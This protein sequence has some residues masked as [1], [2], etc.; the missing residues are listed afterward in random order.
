MSEKALSEIL[1]PDD[2]QFLTSLANEL[3][4]QDT[5]HTATPVIY[6][7]MER[8]K[9]VG[10]DRDYA[11]GV[12]LTL[13]EDGECFY[14]NQVTEAKEWLLEVEWQPEEV[15]KIKAVTCLEDLAIFCEEYD[16]FYSFTGYR[17]TETFTGFF[18]TQSALKRHVAANSYYYKN[19]VS[20]AHYTGW[21]NPELRRLLEIVGKFATVIEKNGRD[22]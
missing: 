17:D 15:A 4:T 5:A 1:T 11:D 16:V 13:G 2:V 6:Q 21:Q 9:D 20:Y 18:L 12:V 14:D 8:T 19:P 7:I 10:I 22:A 3:Q